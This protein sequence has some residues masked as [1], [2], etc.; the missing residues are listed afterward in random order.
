MKRRLLTLI[1]CTALAISLI[2]CSGGGASDDQSGA[3]GEKGQE[4]DGGESAGN[5]GEAVE[6]YIY[7]DKYE[8][9]AALKAACDAYTQSHPN[10]TFIVE[11]SSSGDFYT[12]LKTM[13]N[14]NQ[15]P[16]IFCSKGNDNMAIMV[17]YME[18]LSNESWVPYLSEAAVEAGTIDGVVY[19]FPISIESYGYVY[20]KDLFEQAGI[21]TVPMT[22]SELRDV[23]ETLQNAGI[24]PISSNYADWYQ[25]GMIK[26]MAAI[27]RQDDPTAFIQGMNDGTETLIGNSEVENLAKW[28]DIENEY[29]ASPLNSDFNTEVADFATGK[30]AIML[31]GSWSQ[32]SLDDI[33]PNLNLGLFGLP[34]SEDPSESLIYANCSPF[35]HV[36]KDSAVKEESKAF[37]E[38]LATSEEGQNYLGNEFKL[39]PG[40]T[41]ISVSEDV[42]GALGVATQECL[43]SGELY[44]VYS[45][46]FPDGGAELFGNTVNKYCAG[47]LTPEAFAEEL[48]A[49]WES[50]R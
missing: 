23:C 20:N 17:E 8:I 13:F 9:D 35:W 46:F 40:F 22:V 44:G 26:F 3:Q 11:S 6:I 50:V 49:D 45:S 31:G 14:S 2:G 42:I 48:Q 37:L 34:F 47:Q 25:S 27:A 41:N 24:T 21:E 29:S 5:G 15:G 18:D 32:S 16:D 36:N 1:C 10:V 12:Q 38:W 39:I 7:Q 30:C 33:D 28:V 43:A 4:A 19:G